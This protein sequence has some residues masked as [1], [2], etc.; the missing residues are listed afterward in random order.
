MSEGTSCLW[1]DPVNYPLH[2][3]LSPVAS[4]SSCHRW[5]L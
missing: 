3:A 5:L 4:V 2:D 1:R